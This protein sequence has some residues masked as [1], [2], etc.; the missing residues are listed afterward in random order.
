MKLI[1]FGAGYCSKFIIPKVDKKFEIICTHNSKLKSESFDNLRKVKRLTFQQFCK[2]KSFYFKGVTHIVNS[3]PPVDGRDLVYD[4]IKN[5]D[6]D[7][8]MNLDWIGYLSATSVYGDHSG[9]WVDETSKLRPS[10]SRGKRRK[11]VENLF[12]NLHKKFN[13]PCHI[14]RLPGIYG[15]GRSALERLKSGNNVIVKKQ[16]HFFSRIHVED[17]AAAVILS[18]K[19]KTPG[20]IFNVSDDYPC[21]SEEVIG[22]A[23]NLL[24]NVSVKHVNYDS[25]S[26]SD[27]VRN[28]YLENKRVSNSKIKEI[29]GWT[30]KYE[31]YKLGLNNI[32]KINF[33]G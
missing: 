31:N 7:I 3:I 9:N 21:S 27:K 29:L 18:M 11:Y 26:L 14:F 5:T 20:E 4:L 10:T 22:Y 16:N 19:K 17:I 8:F 13:F 30:P 33:N 25:P 2:K 12:L 23:A 1:F 15:P 32:F 6:N 28:F 24:R